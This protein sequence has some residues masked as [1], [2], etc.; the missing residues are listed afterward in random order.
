VVFNEFQDYILDTTVNRTFLTVMLLFN[1]FSLQFTAEFP[2]FYKSAGNC[3]IKFL[4]APVEISGH[5]AVEHHR[6]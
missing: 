3:S 6:S 4:L 1:T 5:D 2:L